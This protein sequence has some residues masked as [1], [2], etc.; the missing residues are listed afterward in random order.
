MKMMFFLE[1]D[2]DEINDYMKD[3][4]SFK[5]ENP[6]M[7][8]KKRSMTPKILG[9]ASSAI[10]GR[11]INKVSEEEGKLIFQLVIDKGNFNY[12]GYYEKVDK[13]LDSYEFLQIYL[14]DNT[15]KPLKH[16]V[17]EV[18]IQKTVLDKF[19]K[20]YKAYLAYISKKKPEIKK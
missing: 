11:V 16:V 13:E 8:A 12:E 6:F 2:V 9:Y 1:S 18:V 15:V 7:G 17:W 4:L 19:M 10:L 14:L 20:K 5:I 3:F